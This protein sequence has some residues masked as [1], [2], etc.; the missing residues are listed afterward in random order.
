MTG[1]SLPDSTSFL[2]RIRSSW[3][4]LL[5]NVPSFWPTNGD[6]TIARSWRSVPPSHRT[7]SPPVMTSVPTHVGRTHA[8][9]Y[10]IVCALGEVDVPQFQ[11]IGWTVGVPHHRLHRVLL[12]PTGVVA[13]NVTASRGAVHPPKRMVFDLENHWPGVQQQIPTVQTFE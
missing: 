2:S 4:S 10:L 1:V 13:P 9:Q 11:D 3:F 7:P 8:N 5:T 6:S 12:L